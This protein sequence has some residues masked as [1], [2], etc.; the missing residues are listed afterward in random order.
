MERIL[1]GPLANKRNEVKVNHIYIWAGAHAKHLME[2]KSSEE[3]DLAVDTPEKLLDEFG[4][5]LTHFIFQSGS[6][7]VLQCQSEY[8]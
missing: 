3:S 1:N 8:R 6:G 5:C 4:K 2:A 7:A